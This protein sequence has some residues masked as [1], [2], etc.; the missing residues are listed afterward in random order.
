MTSLKAR[1]PPQSTLVLKITKY[2]I[3]SL[4]AM[5]SPDSPKSID[6]FLLDWK[7]TGPL[8]LQES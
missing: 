2:P 4:K 1:E 7:A 6:G 3:D 5:W 8:S